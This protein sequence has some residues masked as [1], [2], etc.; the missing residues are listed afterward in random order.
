[1]D[2]IREQARQGPPGA[3]SESFLFDLA[4][5]FSRP[6]AALARPPLDELP[7]NSLRPQ[8]TETLDL[9][10][11]SQDSVEPKLR[12]DPE[13]QEGGGRRPGEDKMLTRTNIVNNA[14]FPQIVIIPQTTG[15]TEGDSF[16]IKIED[17]DEADM[18]G[19]LANSS[20]QASQRLMVEQLMK[21]LE[22]D[23]KISQLEKAIETQEVI[24]K[25][26]GQLNLL[27]LPCIYPLLKIFKIY[28]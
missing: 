11:T 2:I 1:M 14:R 24:L 20:P 3:N 4:P 15:R 27:G 16:S 25:R 21:S 18:I 8:L 19:A 17:K 13:D 28:L 22:Q 9:S 10:R 7:R 12:F 5:P 23:E 26:L 6:P